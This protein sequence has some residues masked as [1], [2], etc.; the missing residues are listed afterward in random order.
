MDDS[1]RTYQA[2]PLQRIHMPKGYGISLAAYTGRGT[3]H[4]ARIPKDFGPEQSLRGFE[5]TYRN[6]ID[7]IVR[8]TFRI[9]EDR[10]VGYIRDCYAPNSRVFDDYGLQIGSEKIVSDT[11]HT[12]GAFSDIKLI[13]DEV[14]WAGDDEVGFH[15]SHRTTIRGTNDGDSQY[16]PATGKQVDVL[17]I[18]NCVALGN[19]IFLE[20]VLYNSSSMLEQLGFDAGQQAAQLAANPMAGWPRDR[21]A[22]NSLREEASPAQPI[23]VSHPVD[24]FDPDRFVRAAFDRIWNQRDLEALPKYYAADF[25]FEGPTNREFS[26][27]VEYGAF[28][29]TILGAFPDLVLRVDEVYWMGND[30]DGYLV[31]TRWS[32]EATHDG[33]RAYAGPTGKRVQ[34]WGITQQE[35]ENGSVTREWMLFN[36]FDLMIQ[37]V[38]GK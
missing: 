22:W 21:D 13:A 28:L 14:I 23:S 36:E 38:Q 33:S 20:H 3:P 17:V 7:Y 5:D 12:T 37:I 35:I 4:E 29:A 32:A 25:R 11:R 24:G 16:G 18:A 31:A 15:T 2:S 26:G 30:A 27:T 1:D 34:V 6:I 19:D 8:I 9:W 10:D